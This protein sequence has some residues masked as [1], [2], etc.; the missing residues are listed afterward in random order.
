VVLREPKV[1]KDHKEL[2]VLKVVLR[3]PKDN[4]VVEDLKEY[5]EPHQD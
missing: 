1:L 3:E 4:K 5:K 2:K